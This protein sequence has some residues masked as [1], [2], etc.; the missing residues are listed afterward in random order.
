MKAVLCL[1]LNGIDILVSGGADASVIIWRVETGEKLFTLKG[2]TMGVLALAVD[3]QTYPPAASDQ[4]AVVILSAGSDKSIRRWAITADLSSASEIDP[5]NLI[6]AHETSVYNLSFDDDTDLWTASADGTA[7]CLSRERNW[8]ADTALEHGDYVRAVA[9]DEVG[10][11]V[12][13]AGRDEHVKV[14]DKGSGE[15]RFV[16]EGH[17]EEITGLVVVG[18]PIGRERWG[19]SVGIDATI[20]RWRLETQELG[21]AVKKAEDDRNGVE[22]DEGEKEVVGGK[23][24][25][26]GID[27]D[28]QRELD[29]LMNDSE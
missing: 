11:W 6:L 4:G 3:P 20:R 19:V 5:S 23:E 28:E 10:G 12:I 18:P 8:M 2:H 7:K 27:E 21:K 15:L 9:I 17:F 13:S 14:W 16:L 29:E 22:K 1:R 26:F 24:N 25:P